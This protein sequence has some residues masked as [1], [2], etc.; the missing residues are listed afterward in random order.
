MTT[1]RALADPAV[2]GPVA[3]TSAEWF[4]AARALFVVHVAL[5]VF[6]TVAMTTILNGPPGPWLQQEPNA[7]I[8]RLGW[9]Y[10]GPTYVVMGA[11]AALAY[12]AGA[13]GRRRALSLFVV[14]SLVSLGAELLGTST[15]LPFGEY[16]YTTLLGP[17]VLG[18]VPFP[19]PISWFYMLYGSLA[20]VGRLAG[21]NAR[22]D[23]RTRWRWAACAGAV[24]LAWDISMDPA[25]VR[26]A[27]WVW[28]A[29]DL[30]HEAGLP[31]WLDAF[32]TRPVFYG[33]PLSNWFGWYLT[34]TLIARLMLAIVPPRTLVVA[35]A[36]TSLPILL[37]LSNG[38]MP[39][40]LCIRDGLWWAAALGV[41][42]MLVPGVLALRRPPGLR[43]AEA[44]P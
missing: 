15:G 26:T 5:T 3:L 17:R 9:T 7:T 11:L 2:P 13:L 36:P 29:G 37:Y 8:M 1:P 16:H 19:I 42:A 20:I 32:F 27:H 35:L 10:T 23:S 21:T 6:A 44:L 38:I 28:G 18:L 41:L 34:G 14:G 43:P 40:A 12:A 33:M 4:S 22:D 30:F 25:M 39:V 24:L 31:A